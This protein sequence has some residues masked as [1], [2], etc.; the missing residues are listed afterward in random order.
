VLSF[1]TPIREAVVTFLKT[2]GMNEIEARNVL[3]NGK[4]TPIKAAGG[5]TGRQLLV[6]MGDGFGRQQVHQDIWVQI[7]ERR[8]LPM[9][10]R[11]KLVV[12]DDMRRPNEAEMILKHGGEL[13]AV[14][15]LGEAPPVSD[16]THEGL[17]SIFPFHR[18]ILNGGSLDDLRR[19]TT[20]AMA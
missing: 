15:R 4:D 6:A 20:R 3:T 1:A 19:E 8:M 10:P 17:L 18:H 9:L 14:E 13:W 12:F 11:Q 7:G 2:L 5:K 16:N